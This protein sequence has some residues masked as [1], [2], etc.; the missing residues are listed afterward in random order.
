M[1]FPFFNILGKHVGIVT[2]SAITGGG[3]AP[4]YAESPNRSWE[5]DARLEGVE[6]GCVDIAKQFVFNNSNIKV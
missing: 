4:L 6:G 2:K 1:S 5:G 3:T